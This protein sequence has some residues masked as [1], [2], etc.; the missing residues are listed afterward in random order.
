LPSSGRNRSSLCRSPPS[1]ARWRP[2]CS[3]RPEVLGTALRG[4]LLLR[5]FARAWRSAAHNMGILSRLRLLSR[6]LAPLHN[7]TTDEAPDEGCRRGAGTRRGT[8]PRCEETRKL[9]DPWSDG[10]Q[11][12]QSV[13]TA[14]AAREDT[15][16]KLIVRN[17]RIRPSRTAFR[18]KDLGIWHPGPGPRCTTGC[19]PM[20][21]ACGRS[22]SAGHQDR[23]GWP[24]SPLLYWTMAAAQWLGAIPIPVYSDSVADEMAFVLSHAEVTHA[25]VQNQEQVDKLLSW[26]IR[27]RFSPACSMTRTRPARLRPQPPP[28]DLRGHRRRP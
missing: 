25:A 26:P 5:R 7:A 15:F 22:A 17:A 27:C 24:K 14:T 3:R 21:P 2:R 4:R 9:G 20:R 12:G 23:G 1:S 11:G 28:S 8:N 19:A 10:R 6:C 16:P 18:H 13:T